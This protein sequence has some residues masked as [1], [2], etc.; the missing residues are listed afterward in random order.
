MQSLAYFNTLIFLGSNRL[1]ME[2]RLFQVTVQLF[3]R[4]LWG[5]H[6]FAGN[7]SHKS[8][9]ARAVGLIRS[10]LCCC[11]VC[12]GLLFYWLLGKQKLRGHTP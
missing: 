9:R 7:N 12:F 1:H 5:A 4:F 3:R 11:V 6:V 2:Y 8:L 10:A